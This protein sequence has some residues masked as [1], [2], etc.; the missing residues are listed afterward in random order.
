MSP[1]SMGSFK[2]FTISNTSDFTCSVSTCTEG[3]RVRGEDKGGGERVR[4]GGIE[5]GG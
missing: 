5:E 2:S 1:D 3:G 4:Y